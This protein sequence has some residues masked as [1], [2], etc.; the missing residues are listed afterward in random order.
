[1]ASGL[2]VVAARIPGLSE[3]VID[4]ESGLLFDPG[5]PQEG[6]D[7]LRRIVVDDELRVRLSAG[8]KEGAQAFDISTVGRSLEGFY[9]RMLE[10]PV[11]HDTVSA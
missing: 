10:G 6:A 2:P 8:A 4:E 7:R 1:M 3:L 9:K 5:R 11:N